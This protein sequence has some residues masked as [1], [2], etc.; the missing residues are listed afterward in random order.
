MLVRLFQQAIHLRSLQGRGG[1]GMKGAS[2]RDNDTVEEVQQVRDHQSMLFFTTDGQVFAVKAY[3]IPQASR[4]AAGTALP[5]VRP[6][7]K[8]PLRWWPQHGAPMLRCRH[9]AMDVVKPFP[10]KS[11]DRA[12]QSGIEP[13]LK[14]VPI[15]HIVTTQNFHPVHIPLEHA[16]PKFAGKWLA[17]QSSWVWGC[18]PKAQATGTGPAVVQLLKIGKEQKVTAMLPVDDFSEAGFVLLLT[19][20]GWFK[21]VALDQF[22]KKR[23]GTGAIS[24]VS[25]I[26]TIDTQ[27]VLNQCWA[28]PPCFHR[29]LR[30]VPLDCLC[31]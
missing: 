10:K 3:D 26:C 18:E 8:A 2:L 4:T 12:P 28:D 9:I 19:K 1:K 29:A 13:L 20:F 5:Q 27:P 17:R 30:A 15:C 7:H 16:S 23:P 14:L 31:P 11:H 6:P 22:S 24:L 21:R 25:S